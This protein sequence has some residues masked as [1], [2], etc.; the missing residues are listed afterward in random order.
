MP[1]Q[2]AASQSVKDCEREI[3]RFLSQTPFRTKPHQ[4]RRI[5]LLAKCPF[6]LGGVSEDEEAGTDARVHKE[7]STSLGTLTERSG[8]T[9]ECL[10]EHVDSL[11]TRKV[12]LRRTRPTADAKVSSARVP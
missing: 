12:S 3:R 4:R 8:Q 9:A 1:Q 7:P 11:G 2:F 10:K 5:E 6:A